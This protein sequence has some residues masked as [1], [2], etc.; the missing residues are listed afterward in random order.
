[1]TPPSPPKTPLK[2]QSNLGW[3]GGVRWGVI[4]K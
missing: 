2:K 4:F 3:W 1:M